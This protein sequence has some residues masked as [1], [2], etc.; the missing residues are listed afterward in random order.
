[1]K[2]LASS[3]SNTSPEVQGFIGG[4]EGDRGS[5]LWVARDCGWCVCSWSLLSSWVSGLLSLWLAHQLLLLALG[6]VVVVRGSRHGGQGAATCLPAP[7]VVPAVIVPPLLQEAQTLDLTVSMGRFLQGGLEGSLRDTRRA[8]SRHVTH[9][10]SLL[11]SLPPFSPSFRYFSYPQIKLRHW[12]LLSGFLLVRVGILWKDFPNPHNK[13]GLL[14]FSTCYELVAFT[15]SNSL[16][17]HHSPLC[18]LT[19]ISVL[20]MRGP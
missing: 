2:T 16:S 6:W 7:R 15:H 5:A 12:H 8:T 17:P 4:S 14:S 19:I 1:M 20:L 11:S 9:S 3:G 18:I 10:P 13:I